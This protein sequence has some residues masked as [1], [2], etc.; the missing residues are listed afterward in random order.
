MANQKRLT[1]GE[2]LDENG[3]LK[4]AGYATS[5]V[6]RYDRSAIK[7][8]ALR[9]KEWDYYYVGNSRLIWLSE[10]LFCFL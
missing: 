2:L 1:P 5:L 10:F 9:I 6:R 4:E 7:G 3:V 8:G